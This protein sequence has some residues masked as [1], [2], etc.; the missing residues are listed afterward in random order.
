VDAAALPAPLVMGAPY[1]A[2]QDAV[3]LTFLRASYDKHCVTLVGE[4]EAEK[5]TTDTVAK[6]IIMLES[7][8]KD[9]AKK[10]ERGRAWRLA[11]LLPQEHKWGG[12]GS[13]ADMC[14]P[15]APPSPWARKLRFAG[16][17]HRAR[18]RHP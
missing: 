15:A 14:A 17:S 3:S 12:P 4:G 7:W 2:A 6:R 1:T 5:M 8:D 9:G 10:G 11:D 13:E 18:A 16:R